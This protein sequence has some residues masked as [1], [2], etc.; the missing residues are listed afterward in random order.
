MLEENKKFVILELIFPCCQV[1][2]WLELSENH[3]SENQT[4]S[5][6][7]KT[8]F[9]TNQSDCSIARSI[10]FKYWTRHFAEGPVIYLA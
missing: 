9:K 4:T 3:L 8:F 6:I 2:R 5:L 1:P 7:Q 10:F